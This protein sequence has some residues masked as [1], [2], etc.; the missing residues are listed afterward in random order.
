MSIDLSSIGFKTQAH[1]L[2]YDWKRAALYALGIG[3]RRDELDYLYEGRGP[4]VFPTF[5]VV[6]TYPVVD[7]LL[8]RTGGERAMIVH[9]G[10]KLDLY[11]R[12]PPQGTFHT[13]GTV[14]AI[15]DLR[16]MAQVLLKTTTKLD[17]AICFETEWSILVRGA[18]GF[19]GE[20]RAK[21]DGPQIPDH[22][23]PDFVNVAT[24]SPEQAL[25]YRLSGDLNPIHAD[26]E[27]AAKAGF[28]RGPILHG[29]CTF[30]FVARAIV[31]SVCGGDG[32][33]LRSLTAQFKK[34]VWPGETLRTE[35]YT[36]GD[37]TIAVRAFA[38]ERP[39]PVLGQCWA[40]LSN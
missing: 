34:P 15:Y 21:A 14:H 19:G 30:G 12:M 24:T 17:D 23:A 13:V 39:E 11:R 29:M 38:G 20:R 31:Q 5:A 1:I 3:A 18:G 26:P 7:E 33:K 28:E 27:L 22:K 35:G 6:A 9:G 16:I 40:Q 8:D 36:L 37:G 32:D 25:L 10:Q 4:R 2:T